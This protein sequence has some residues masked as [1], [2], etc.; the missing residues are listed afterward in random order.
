M[1]KIKTPITDEDILNLKL[2]DKL[3][4]SGTIYTGRDAVLPK[5]VDLLEK[6]VKLDIDIQG[7]GIMHTAVS[8][9]GIATTSSNKKEIESSIGPLSKHGIKLHI[10]KGA[11][12]E[13]TKNALK[14]YNSTYLVSPPV[15]ALLTD[16]VIKKECVM[17]E[18]EGIEG[19]F[20]LQVKDLPAVVAIVNG[21]SIY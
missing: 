12:S 5:L 8:D 3:L 9:A 4:I 21:K 1:I 19:C 11:L 16:C 2:N 7:T 6:E 18:E 17:F 10:G 13:K 20:K 14:K 15:A